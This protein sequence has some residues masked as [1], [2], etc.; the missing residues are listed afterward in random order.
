[1]AVFPTVFVKSYILFAFSFIRE[2]SIWSMRQMSQWHL[3]HFLLTIPY[4]NFNLCNWNGYY[5]KVAQASWKYNSKS[6]VNISIS[7]SSL[8]KIL[9]TQNLDFV[10]FEGKSTKYYL[11]WRFVILTVC[12]TDSLLYTFKRSY[13]FYI[14]SFDFF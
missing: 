11:Y 9:D 13:I 10:A 1:M 2:T 6:C 3:S 8:S 14:L 12:Y 4:D 5:F 7:I